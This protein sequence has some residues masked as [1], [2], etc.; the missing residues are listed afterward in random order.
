M[1]PKW[2]TDDVGEKSALTPAGDSWLSAALYL[3]SLRGSHGRSLGGYLYP[4]SVNVLPFAWQ[5][6][7][8]ER[9]CSFSEVCVMWA[10]CYSQPGL[11]HQGLSQGRI[12]AAVLKLKGWSGRHLSLLL[13]LRFHRQWFMHRFLQLLMIQLSYIPF[14]V[15]IQLAWWG[16][17][18]QMP[19][20]AKNFDDLLAYVLAKEKI[21]C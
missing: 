16:S 7:R 1:D 4:Q 13:M 18:L 6:L 21:S 12:S 9:G 19:K 14:I 8:S 3:L 2:M 20:R 17:K 5:L 11:Q 10:A 15:F